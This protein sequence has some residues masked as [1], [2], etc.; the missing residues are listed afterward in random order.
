MESIYSRPKEYYE[1]H[2]D[3]VIL[4]LNV[5]CAVCRSIGVAFLFIFS[6]IQKKLQRRLHFELLQKEKEGEDGNYKTTD[7]HGVT[8]H[9][10]CESTLKENESLEKLS[11]YRNSYESDFTDSLRDSCYSKFN[12]DEYYKKIL[13]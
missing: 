5:L 10:S 6:H 1:L 4:L 11:C 7:A 2:I 3:L 13:K 8:Y 12:T 9:T